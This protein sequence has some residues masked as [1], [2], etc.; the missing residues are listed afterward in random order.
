MDMSHIKKQDMLCKYFASIG[1]QLDTR[2]IAIGQDECVGPGPQST[3][4]GS[5]CFLKK[6]QGAR[7]AA[8]PFKL[9]RGHHL[10]VPRLTA[11]F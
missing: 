3:V 1:V 7:A 4:A 8:L 2:A 10:T 6:S 11:L 5:F 9:Q